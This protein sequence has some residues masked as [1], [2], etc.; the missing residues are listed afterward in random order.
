M[1]FDH[2]GC[3]LE[4]HVQVTQNFV[5]VKKITSVE[6]NDF[7]RWLIFRCKKDSSLTTVKQR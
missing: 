2:D 7:E 5:L 1:S 4:P 6:F 3:T